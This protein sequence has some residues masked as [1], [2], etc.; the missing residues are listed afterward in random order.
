MKST[1]LPAGLLL[2]SLV[3]AGCGQSGPLY[4]PGD[5]STIH[6]PPEQAQPDQQKAEEDKN[7]NKDE[8][9]DSQ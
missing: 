4:I 7:K 6:P 8:D 1:I 2:L 3:L 5:P 9:A